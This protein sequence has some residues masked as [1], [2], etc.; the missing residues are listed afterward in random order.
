MGTGHCLCA[1]E[2]D[3]VFR[4]A[5]VIRVD[6]LAAHIKFCRF[7]PKYL[8]GVLRG[9]T[10]RQPL[11]L[12]SEPALL[13]AINDVYM[14]LTPAVDTRCPADNSDVWTSDATDVTEYPALLARCFQQPFHV[15]LSFSAISSLPWTRRSVGTGQCLCA[16]AFK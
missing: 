7:W 16:F 3:I 2:V 13:P 1:F 4:N 8:N 10:V 12:T 14:V 6:L 5:E 9:L 11:A 15:R